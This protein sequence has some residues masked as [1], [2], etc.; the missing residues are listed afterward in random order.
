M[1]KY[2][3]VRKCTE[4]YGGREHTTVCDRVNEGEGS[5]FYA[6]KPQ[7]EPANYCGIRIL[8]A[9]GKGREHTKKYVTDLIP[10]GV[11]ALLPARG[12]RSKKKARSSVM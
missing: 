4:M 11:P 5:P 9:A 10:A 8:G 12:R 3:N 6:H 2:G 7:P 1:G